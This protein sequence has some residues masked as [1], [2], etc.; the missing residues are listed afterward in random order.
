M[1]GWQVCSFV[2]VRLFLSRHLAELFLFP[3]CLFPTCRG[4][5]QSKEEETCALTNNGVSGLSLLGERRR[6]KVCFTSPTT[7]QTRRAR[8]K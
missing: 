5:S 8:A 4:Q 6:V 2:C 1:R 7:H 3:P